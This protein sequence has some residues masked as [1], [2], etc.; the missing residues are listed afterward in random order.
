MEETFLSE[1]IRELADSIGI[2]ALGFAKVA[3]FT[4]YALSNS[5]RR[6]PKLSLPDAKN[7]IVAGIY[8]GGL[9]LPAWTNP[10]YG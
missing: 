3:E 2:D 5:K 1:K 8:I 10:W 6:D 4:G 7:I 9:T